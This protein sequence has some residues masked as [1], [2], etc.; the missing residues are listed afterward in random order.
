MA[1]SV[2]AEWSELY[3]RFYRKQEIYTMCWQNVDLNRHKVAC[4]NF[5]GPIAI[6]RDD[7]KIVQLRS[8]SARAK[9]MIYTSSG[10]LIKSYI[11]DRP[12]GRL[13]NLGWTADEVLLV[14]MQ[15]G[16]VY[17]YN[18]HGELAQKKFS[19]G[20][21]VWDQGVAEC[22]IWGTGLVCLTEANQLWAVTN[23]EDP[24]PIKLAD[25]HLEEP[26]HCMAIVEPQ[27]TVSGNLEVLL[28]VGTSVLVV[29][30]DG[31]HDHNL[32]IGPLQKMT[33]SP[34]GTF[35]A[36]FT[37]D[38]R[39]LVVS[40][41]F[42]KTLVDFDTQ[43][44][45]PPE[46]LVWCGLDALLL[47]WEETLM[48]VGPYG[49][50]VRY[51]YDEALFLI[52]ECDGVRILSNTYMEFLELLSE[53]TVSIFKIGSTT[54]AA[55]LY[56]ALDHFDKRSSKADENIRLIMSSLP[57]AVKACIDAAGHEFDISQ[58]RTLMRA[59]AYG[60]AFCSQFPR[61]KFKDMCRTLRVLNAVRRFEIGIPLTVQQ[62]EVLTP[63][64]L[65]ARLVNQHRHLLAFR[66]SDHLGLGQETVLIHWA[67]TKIA[68]ASDVPD[69]LLL[70]MLVEKLKECPMIS[71]AVVAANAHR[72]GRRKLA[73]M[74]LDYEPRS[75]EQVPLL[76]SMGEEER[77]LVKAI[78]SGD[79][80]LVYFTIFH[81][82][83]Q[84]P[85]QEFFR[86]IQTRPLARDL[87][88]VYARE[89]EPELL[90]TFYV[91]GG[92]PQCCAELFLRESWNSGQS[93]TVRQGSALQGPRVKLI[94]QAAELYSQTKDNSFEA[95]AA[96]EHAKLLK[97]Q[98]DLEAA[99]GQ[100]IFVDSS[101]SDTIR[102]CI[103]LGNNRAAQRIRTDFKVPDKRFYWLKIFA[104]ATIKNWEAL[105]KF[106]KEK[107]PP[108]GY[109]PFVEAC[110]EEDEKDEALKYIVKL[111]DPQERAEAYEKLGMSA[112]AA[113]AAAQTKESEI[114]GRLKAFGQNS[115][116]GALFDSLR[117][118]LSLPGVS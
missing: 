82:W 51:P 32:L 42:S 90:K 111:S 85:T 2:A 7:S 18:I 58:Q 101:I 47:Y 63:Q 93:I 37:H 22:I 89:S 38:G 12:G 9:L 117:D 45:L 74:L 21:E 3:N 31:V 77:A 69:N 28:A 81:I 112:E 33:V 11:W 116:A 1:V 46:Q 43:S 39:L 10:V 34:N 50:S 56:D 54:P 79:T 13:V 71:Y 16:T 15:D 25:P 64:V 91:S 115:P 70:E 49:D 87:F 53:A 95:K 86:I 105:E 40:I 114:L 44:G 106:S 108:V 27:F 67:C 57:E 26:P 55:M 59:A 4:S 8:E 94:E 5:G 92:Q 104:L 88:I 110:I 78:E 52:P 96:E 113:N 103:T 36:C 98:Q 83:S 62:L 80:D 29:D 6:I 84:K 23:L 60:R 61:N 102:T 24:Q 30:A 107:K 35:V 48:M 20:K 72:K 75:S 14:L 118:R 109:K 100:P 73:A 76:T 66:I 99:T 41:D 97:V 68:A 19:F 65:I 17:R